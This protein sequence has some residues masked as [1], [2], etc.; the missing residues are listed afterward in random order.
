MQGGGR[1]GARWRMSPESH[2]Y[3]SCTSWP[4]SLL[5]LWSCREWFKSE[6]HQ[7]LILDTHAQEDSYSCPATKKLIKAQLFKWTPRWWH[8]SYSAKIN[9]SL[10]CLPTVKDGMNVA[11]GRSWF[12]HPLRLQG[13]LYRDQKGGAPVF[14]TQKPQVLTASYL[15]FLSVAWQNSFA[16][17]KET[18]RIDAL[19]TIR[20]HPSALG[21]QH[22]SSHCTI[23]S[24][25]FS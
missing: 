8:I 7:Q 5:W 14:G 13:L 17:Q 24:L 15:T 10:T 19:V 9:A 12:Q 18:S 22:R 4:L 20:V 25:S 16:I 1:G 3:W 6:Q 21:T 2:L 11:W 23:P